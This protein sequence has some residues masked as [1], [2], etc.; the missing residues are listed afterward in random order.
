MRPSVSI[1]IRYAGKLLEAEQYT[2]ICD[3][4][5]P[6][7]ELEEPC[8]TMKI[9]FGKQ[10]A[11]SVHEAKITLYGQPFVSNAVAKLAGCGSSRTRVGNE[12]LI[13]TT[14]ARRGV[15]NIVPVLGLYHNLTDGILVLLMEDGGRPMTGKER[16][17]KRLE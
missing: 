13:C 3:S 11:D 8:T 5:M 2:R 17:K 10:L 15:Q 12:Y 16:T 9:I 7:Q 1:S 14:L 6:L 4:T